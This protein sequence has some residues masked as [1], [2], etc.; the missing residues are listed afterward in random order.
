MDLVE[1]AEVVLTYSTLESLDYDSGGQLYG[2]ME[3]SLTGERVAGSLRL[4]NLASRRPETST[5][6]RCGG[7]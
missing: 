7:S 6:R 2:T 5:S 1:L 3:G 4:T